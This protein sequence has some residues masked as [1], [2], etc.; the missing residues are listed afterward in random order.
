MDTT[1]LKRAKQAL[2][3]THHSAGVVK[4]TT[5]IRCAEQRDKLSFG[6]ELIPIFHTLM[7]ATDQ[8]YIVFLHKTVHN[9]RAECEGDTT[10]ILAP[11]SYF[12]LRIRPEEITQ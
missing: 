3:N 7:R 10:V 8:V 5:V 12:L 1:Y 2:I 6:E 9:V 4:F 11:A